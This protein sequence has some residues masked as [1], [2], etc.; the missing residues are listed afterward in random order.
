M[1]RTFVLKLK[2]QSKLFLF[3]QIKLIFQNSSFEA[4]LLRVYCKKRHEQ[5]FCKL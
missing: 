2:G 1:K 4:K 5:V 3:F